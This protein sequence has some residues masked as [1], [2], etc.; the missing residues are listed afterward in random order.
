MDTEF[1][2]SSPFGEESVFHP[3]FDK[4]DLKIRYVFCQKDDKYTYLYFDIA[5]RNLSTEKALLIVV[6]CEVFR[7][8]P[9]VS[10]TI[11]ISRNGTKRF[12]V[13]FNETILS[14]SFLC[15]LMESIS[16]LGIKASTLC[17]L[18]KSRANE[19]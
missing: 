1:W 5:A 8:E 11:D 18:Q 13:R 15:L 19:T 10:Q 4:K 12:R 7:D 16:R 3:S 6:E 2:K 14:K 9:I 17:A